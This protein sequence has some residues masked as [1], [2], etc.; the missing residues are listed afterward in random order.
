MGNQTKVTCKHCLLCCPPLVNERTER[1]NKARVFHCGILVSF[2]L[3]KQFPNRPELGWLK[4]AEKEADKTSTSL[5]VSE[6]KTCCCL[7]SFQYQLSLYLLHDSQS[8]KAL[9]SIYAV[10][11]F[12]PFCCPVLTLLGGDFHY[13]LLQ[14]TPLISWLYVLHSGAKFSTFVYIFIFS[15]LN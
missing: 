7:T 11:C 8:V 9:I 6:I 10:L 1:R 13:T 5:D 4:E 15:C 14:V 3:T 12:E 2:I